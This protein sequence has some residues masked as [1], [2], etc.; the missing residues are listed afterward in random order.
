MEAIIGAIGLGR[1]KRDVFCLLAFQNGD[2][3]VVFQYLKVGTI[4]Y[5]TLRS[6]ACSESTKLSYLTLPYL[7]LPFQTKLVRRLGASMIGPPKKSSASAD[8]QRV[9]T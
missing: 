6:S 2:M 8:R 9:S 3:S 4:P 1:A 7:T 5:L